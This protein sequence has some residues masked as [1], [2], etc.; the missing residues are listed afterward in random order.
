MEAGHDEEIGD[1]VGSLWRGVVCTRSTP[2]MRGSRLPSEA[3]QPGDE[4]PDFEL[5]GTDGRTYRLSDY[6]GKQAV[7]LAWFFVCVQAPG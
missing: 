1:R 3:P 5:R 6:R 7:V 4:A 2:G